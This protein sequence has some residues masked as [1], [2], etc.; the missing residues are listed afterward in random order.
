MGWGNSPPTSPKAASMPRAPTKI[1]SG[2]RQPPTSSP[3]AKCQHTLFWRLALKVG[4]WELSPPQAPG[5]SESASR[6]CSAPAAGQ[7]PNFQL[8]T[9]NSQRNAPPP[10][11]R[12]IPPHPL[13][14]HR[15]PS[16][17][18]HEPPSSPPRI[19]FR[20]QRGAHASSV[21]PA[22]SC[23]RAFARR[24]SPTRRPHPVTS[25]PF[26]RTASR[27][28]AGVSGSRALARTFR[29]DHPAGC[30]TEHAGGTVPRHG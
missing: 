1:P 8:P 12:R 3:P 6:I 9:F 4:R 18:R 26:F 11:R 30:R 19:A 7:T 13:I 17:Q 23:R 25:A 15:K 16:R 10:H 27:H 22:A 20:E 5:L 14:A 28:P 29:A 21:L 24:S 2:S